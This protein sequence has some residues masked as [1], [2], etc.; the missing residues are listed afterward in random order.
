MEQKSGKTLTWSLPFLIFI[1]LIVSFTSF[2]F[3]LFSNNYKQWEEEFYSSDLEIFDFQKDSVDLDEKILEYNRTESEYAFI[4]FNETESI[5]L[6]ASSL[7]ESLPNWI[8]VQKVALQ[9]SRGYWIFFVKGKAFDLSL[10][11]FQV[12]IGKEEIQS[13]DIYIDDI[14][15]GNFSFRNLGLGSV[16]ESADNGLE[17]ATMLVNDGNFAGRVFE[18]IELGEKSIVIRSRNISN[19]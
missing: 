7:N 15:L 8:E 3:F 18:N 17:R 12:A 10:P 4:E 5:Y 19:F 11:W 14:F 9:P 6:F 16:V 1:I 13:V 2:L